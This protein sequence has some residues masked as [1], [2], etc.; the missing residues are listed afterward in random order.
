MLFLQLKPPI[1]INFSKDLTLWV[2]THFTMTFGK[3]GPWQKKKLF[4]FA[5]PPLRGGRSISVSIGLRWYNTRELAE[6]FQVSEIFI[7]K[8]LE[9]ENK[10]G[11]NK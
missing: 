10:R 11:K 4:N 7:R 3:F 6:E 2:A 5:P 1:F 9:F 8:R